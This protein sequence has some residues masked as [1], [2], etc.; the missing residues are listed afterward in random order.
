MPKIRLTKGELKRQRDDLK[1]FLRF[2]P[3][4]ELKKRQLIQEVNLVNKQISSLK[5]ES[6]NHLEE[7][8]KWID[9]FAD[10]VDLENYFKI[11]EIQLEDGNVSGVNIPV[12]K[13]VLFEETGYDLITTPVWIDAGIESCRKQVLF[14]A[15]IKV[16]KKQIDI[17][18]EELRI[19]IQRIKL[20]EEVKIPKARES[21]RIIQIFL[22][23]QQTAEVVRGKIAKAKLKH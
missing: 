14:N 18:K 12:L 17:L 1:M 2:L 5:K 3:T 11:K 8:S 16:H 6:E 4:L 15:K 9:V 20:F 7:I 23:D 10:E 22:A 19:T 21:I 13:N